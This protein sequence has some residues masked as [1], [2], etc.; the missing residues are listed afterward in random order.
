MPK[1]AKEA[2]LKA[3]GMTTVFKRPRD[4]VL[5]RVVLEVRNIVADKCGGA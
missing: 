5:F 1:A 2:L 4:K 3:L